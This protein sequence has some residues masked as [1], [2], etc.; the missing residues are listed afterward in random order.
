LKRQ[1]SKSLTYIFCSKIEPV[2]NPSVSAVVDYLALGQIGAP[3][4]IHENIARGIPD[5]VREFAAHFE[6]VA[7][8]K[9]VLAASAVVGEREFEGVRAIFVHDFE[10]IYAVAKALGHFAALFVPDKT[11]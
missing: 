7:I 8:E 9:D 11:V 5:L 6:A 4:E 1:D 2:Q 10:W 3:F